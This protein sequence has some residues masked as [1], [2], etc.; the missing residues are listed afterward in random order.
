[1][2]LLNPPALGNPPKTY[3]H[4]VLVEAA[5]PTLYISGQVGVDSSGTVSPDFATQ[6]R[7]AWRNVEAVLAAAGMSVSDI[8]KTTVF[9]VRPEDFP[10]FVEVRSG[11]LKGHRPA[12]SLVFVSSLVDPAWKV[13]IEAVAIKGKS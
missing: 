4:G 10:V 12:S 1:M 6:A 13:E 7:T 8:I 3:T 11:V 9:L 2:K 5:G